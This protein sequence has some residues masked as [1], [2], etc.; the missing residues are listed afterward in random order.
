MA[1]GLEMMLKSFGIDPEL[2]KRQAGEV[3]ASVKAFD[4]R[5]S[6]VERKLDLLLLHFDIV[7]IPETEILGMQI[8]EMKRNVG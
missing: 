6:N 3:A 2:I 7:D 8:E 4:N 1:G 5:L